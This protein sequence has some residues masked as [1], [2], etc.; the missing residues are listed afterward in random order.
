MQT[1]KLH[2]TYFSILLKNPLRELQ[3]LLSAPCFL[4]PSVYVHIQSQAK[5]HTK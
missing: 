4:T 5:F 2:I 3:I 1:I